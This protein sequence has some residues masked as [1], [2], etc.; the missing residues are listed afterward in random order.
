[1]A[2]KASSFSLWQW[3]CLGWLGMVLEGFF[4]CF[5]ELGNEGAG[6]S[7]MVTVPLTL[8]GSA[9]ENVTPNPD[10]C[11]FYLL[12]H[13]PP[14]L[15]ELL[16]HAVTRMYQVYFHFSDTLLEII[17]M[18][19]IFNFYM[20]WNYWN[21]ITSGQCQRFFSGSI[22]SL[23]ALS[24]PLLFSFFFVTRVICSWKSW[25]TGRRTSGIDW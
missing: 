10:C 9:F 19:T 12:L 2:S 1:M 4:V 18:Q 15:L 7:Q 21:V 14:S 20:K 3:L 8:T 5:F 6:W 11:F 24:L 23:F 13:C 16:F 25:F 22:S 17:S